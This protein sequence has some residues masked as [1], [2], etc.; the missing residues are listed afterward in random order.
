MSHAR[1]EILG[2]EVQIFKRPRSPYW[3][4][5][6]T[7]GGRQHRLSTKKE[8]LAQ[9]QDAA[10]DWYLELKGKN[11]WGGG[12]KP[13]GTPFTKAADTFLEEYETLVGHLRNR[14]YV[15]GH[16]R[17]VKNHL[18]PFFGSMGL[19]DIKTGTIHAYRMH[20][21][22]EPPPVEPGPVEYLPN[23]RKKPKPRPWTRPAPNTIHQEIV[24]LR[25]I[26][27][28]ALRHGWIDYMP[29]LSPAFQ[30]REK[31]RHRAWFTPK[32]YRQLQDAAKRRI[33][34]PPKERWKPSCETLFDFI[35]FMANTGL[36]PD[37]AYRLQYRDVEIVVDETTGERI[38]DI[39]VRGKRGTGYCK[40]MPAAV[41]PFQRM[42]KRNNGQPT[43]V[44]FAKFP[45]E[46]WKTVLKEE[47]LV[48]DRDNNRRTPYS[49][50]HTYICLRLMEGADIYQ[51]AKNC[52]TSVEMI[53]KHY[54]VHLKN[55]L[56]ASAINV[57]KQPLKTRASEPR[58]RASEPNPSQ[59]VNSAS[60]RWKSPL[61]TTPP[62][63]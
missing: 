2:G 9:A 7:V 15:D 36:R 40:S 50:R 55:T 23:G 17:R 44:I 10:E 59:P 37:E 27:K 54:A 35:V 46:L 28:T 51:I 57:R 33:A 1:H 12:I 43:D 60:R 61:A 48:F 58:T 29:S 42:K 19:Q 32:E 24:T 26:L 52:R 21:H 11:R 3:Q 5:S 53:E 45:R 18:M 62:L 13:R 63:R 47:G 22:T 20:R 56:D 8:S 14:D 49:L 34:N 30:L 38:L 6:A 31:I 4:C 16:K 39:D 25:Q 41:Y